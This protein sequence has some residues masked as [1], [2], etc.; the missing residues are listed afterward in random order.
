MKRIRAGYKEKGEGKKNNKKN[1]REKNE[2][3]ILI[4]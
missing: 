1:K 3:K 4:Y 2:G